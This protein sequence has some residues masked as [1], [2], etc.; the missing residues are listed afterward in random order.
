MCVAV[1]N[2]DQWREHGIGDSFDDVSAHARHRGSSGA[3]SG[4]GS[5]PGA[6]ANS[7]AGNTDEAAQSGPSEPLVRGGRAA[8]PGQDPEPSP[9]IDIATTDDSTPAA[10]S[11][12]QSPG[13]GEMIAGKMD[14]AGAVAATVAAMASS[15]D[16]SDAEP[17]W[18][19]LIANWRETDAVVRGMATRLGRGWDLSRG[20]LKIGGWREFVALRHWIKQH[21]ELIAVVATLGRG[22]ESSQPL[23]GRP[24]LPHGEPPQPDASQRP[25]PRP[26]QPDA[27]RGPPAPCPSDT[28]GVTRSDEIARML[29]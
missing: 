21:P 1:D 28:R 4:S 17:D 11:S 23:P 12:G 19:G 14:R 27:G 24:R 25:R 13:A 29:P 18:D 10:L 9:G 7:P 26:R 8:G 16:L 3:D 5:G 22:S 6:G 2:F 15:T 20:S